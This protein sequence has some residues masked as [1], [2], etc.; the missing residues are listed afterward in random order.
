MPSDTTNARPDDPVAEVPAALSPK[1]ISI[2]TILSLLMAAMLVPALVFALVLL[3][4]NNQAQ[5]DMLTSLAEATAGSISETVDRQL[6][7]TLTTLRVLSTSQP[8]E[9]GNLADFYF[10]ARN[11]LR[12]SGSHLIVT[13][14]SLQQLINTRVPYGTPLGRIAD[15]ET[16]ARAL[17]TLEPQVS[18]AFYGETAQNWV[19]NVILPLPER[20]APAR[21]LIIAHDAEHLTSALGSGNLRGGW[22]AVITDREGTVLS[23]S[24]LSSDI[25]KPFLLAETLEPTEG[26]IRRQV[27]IEGAS[28]E[29]IQSV[30]PLSGW[31]TI[32]WAPTS[33]IH[34]PMARSLRLLV[35]GGVAII[36][37]GVVLAWLLGRQIATPIRRLARD[38]QRLGAG[39]NVQAV[40][41]PV[42]E[43]A[44]VSFA[45]AQAS[46]DRQAALN[47]IRF[48]MREVAHRSK[49]QLTVVSS[50]AKQTAR[51]ARTLPGFHDSFQKRIQGLARSTDLLIAGGVAGVELQELIR[52]QI[53]PFQPSEAER[54]DIKGPPFRLSNQAAQTLGLALHEL[55]TNAA[56][57]GAFASNDGRLAVNWKAAGD[58]L[59]LVWREQVP[60]LRR[61]A[62]PTTGFGT[63]VIERM[64][65]GALGAKIER[66]F[67]RNGL[68][69]RFSIPI[70]KI[71]PEQNE[72]EDASGAG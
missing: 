29:K 60:R 13:D 22:N 28:Y 1:R 57:Y 34:A 7:G 49:N 26:T 43:I 2:I 18:N 30:S 45:M 17:A 38:A 11:A 55:A 61:K 37:I 66:V 52:A 35:L 72:V 20:F 5:Q 58:N 19:F 46:S 24:F 51:H 40:N 65:G 6:S 71:G 8:L 41:Y 62:R 4:R 15:T 63:E 50:I 21:L 16:A 33:V 25:G 47:E 69:M 14:E 9:E 31:Q 32:V 36:A 23:S 42:Q 59:E 27:S 53:E 3:Q 10:R 70:E 56:K 48:L 54:L 12:D 64:L 44:T 68:E 39:E 67:H